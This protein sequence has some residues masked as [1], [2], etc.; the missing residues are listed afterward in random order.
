[1]LNDQE[2]ENGFYFLFKTRCYFAFIWSFQSPQ[3]LAIFLWTVYSDILRARPSAM[4][5]LSIGDD[6]WSASS[7]PTV[8]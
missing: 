6:R 4:T 1:M 5:N 7:G 8:R 3:S 2:M